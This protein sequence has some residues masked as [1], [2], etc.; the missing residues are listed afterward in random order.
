MECSVQGVSEART[1]TTHVA[2]TNQAKSRLSELIR[3]AEV[4]GYGLL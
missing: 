1:M 2:N 4:P 3:E